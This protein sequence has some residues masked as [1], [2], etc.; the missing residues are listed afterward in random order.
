MDVDV[1]QLRRLSRCHWA[2]LAVL[3]LG[4]SLRVLAQIAYWPALFYSDSWEYVK[5][6]FSGPF[7][8]FGVD[9]PSGYPLLIHLLLRFGR[10]PA[11]LTIVQHLA[12]LATGTVAYLFLVKLRV[13]PWLAA[14]A[15]AVILLDSYA[16]ALEQYVMAETF[17]TLALLLCAVVLVLRGDHPLPLAASGLLL[18][19]AV[20]LRLAAAF[21]IP[22]FLAYVVFKLRRPRLV[23]TALA[24]FALPLLGYAAIHA[25]H[26]RGF[27]FTQT[28]SYALYGRI[29]PIAD[30]RGAA[31]P[32]EARPLCETDAE[33][34][35]G[36][37]PSQYVFST[38]SPARRLLGWDTSPADQRV[39]REFSWAIVRHRPL[40]YLDMVSSDFIRF[41]EP[42]GPGVDPPLLFASRHSFRW[43]S[44]LPA[45]KLRAAYLPDYRRHVREPSGFLQAYQRWFHTP[46]WLMG[47][48]SLA[49]L[50]LTLGA[51]RAPRRED[52]SRRRHAAYLFGGMGLSLLVGTVATVELT[53][54][55]MVPA[56]PLLVCGGTLAL[57]ELAS[58]WS[59][60]RVGTVARTGA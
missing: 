21:A 40:A 14:A 60:V 7:V 20:T 16:I 41:F 59:P 1:Q 32:A 38:A 36:W 25:A 58:T 46:R 48:L 13:R 17:F 12:G 18:A 5:L 51:T 4:I 43:E 31:I 10:E 56:V 34:A 37:A 30:C 2:F 24:A 29:A 22:A 54:R 50:L 57:V 6:A 39:L 27:G 15:A 35:R 33:R 3:S 52:D 42:G 45:R 28:G 26:G 11:T 55:F 47:A 19:G 44:R 9:R 8:E 23:A 53:V 49:I